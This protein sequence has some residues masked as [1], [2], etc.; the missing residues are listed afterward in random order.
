VEGKILHEK[1]HEA[2][3]ESRG[4][5]RIVRGLRLRCLRLGLVGV[6]DVVEFHRVTEGVKLPGG[7][8]LWQPFPV[9]YKRGKP[10]PD[11][12]DEVQLCGQ[13]LCL[14]EMLAGT[15]PSGA[16][17]YGTIRRRHDVAFDATLRRR[18]EA[19]AGRLHE[20]IEAG[21]TPSAVYS[22]KCEKCSLLNLCMPQ[23]AGKGKSVTGYLKSQ[24]HIP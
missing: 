24:I 15:I 7:E 19:A 18:T 2:D 13:A 14:E 1:V 12:C 6:A 20:L 16:L 23:T 22:K 4:N 8:G 10:K 9:E 21:L 5:V 3:A 11:E 17:F